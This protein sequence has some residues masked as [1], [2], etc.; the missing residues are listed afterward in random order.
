L[1][2]TGLYSAVSWYIKG[3]QERCGLEV[4]LDLSED[5]GRLPHDM[6]L[7]I[8]RLVQEGL[9]NIHRHSESK[10]AAIRIAR[11]SNQITLKIQDQGKGM[12]TARLAAVR[13]GRSGF[14]IRGMKERLCQF[15]GTIDIESDGAGTRVVATIPLPKAAL[16]ENHDNVK[17]LQATV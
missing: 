15:E 16:Q 4:H 1:D 14:G 5:F 9:T 10:T 12:S 8:F 6:E 17:S 7:L 2:E 11:E 3:L 13:S